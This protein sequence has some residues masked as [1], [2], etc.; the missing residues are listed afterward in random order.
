MHQDASVET[1]DIVA[2]LDDAA[3]P[4]T[5]HI[6][7]QLHAERAVIPDGVDPAVDL[8]AR[9]DE[10]ATLCERDDDVEIGNRGGRVGGRRAGERDR[11]IGGDAHEVEAYPIRRTL[12]GAPESDPHNGGGEPEQEQPRR[13]GEE[14]ERLANSL[15][16]SPRQGN[17]DSSAHVRR[18]AG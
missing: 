11:R 9:E 10:A 18:A 4:G 17:F 12:E 13:V 6:V 2:L 15:M 16:P 5:L 7:L 1:N 3:P 14:Q 8:R